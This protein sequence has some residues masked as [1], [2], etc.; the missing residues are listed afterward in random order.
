MRERYEQEL[1]ILNN[2]LIEMGSLVEDNIQNSLR[3]LTERDD[4]ASRDVILRDRE[5]DV[6][7]RDIENLAM[8][9]LLRQQPVAGDLRLISSVL[10]I[11]TDLERIGDHAQDISEISLSMPDDPLTTEL[12][13]IN[14][15]FDACSFMIKSAIDSFIAE[16]VELAQQCIEHDDVVDDLYEQLRVKLIGL[17]RENESRAEELIDLLQIAKYLERVGDHTEN[18]AEW[19]IYSVTGEHVDEF[20]KW[21][22]NDLLR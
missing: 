3:A 8:S 15:M 17:I 20:L 14:K 9:L 11:I 22:K 21:D 5:V 19:V 13:Y 10:K 12:D 16:D 7:E 18:I 4:E 2:K 1:E 6:M